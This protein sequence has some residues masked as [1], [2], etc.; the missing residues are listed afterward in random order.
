MGRHRTIDPADILAAAEQ[1]VA[2]DGA[3]HLTIDAVAAEA[4]ISKAS[5]I[6]NFASKRDLIAAVVKKAVAADNELHATA[7]KKLGD[8]KNN[9]IRGR[10]AAAAKPLPDDFRPIALQLCAALAQ[11][12]ELR[13]II[14]TNQNEVIDAIK[15]TSS[16]PRGA[17]LAYLALEG[18]KLLESLDYHQWSA[19]ERARIVREIE[20]LVDKT[21]EAK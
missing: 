20:W 19:K 2:R 8:A 6:Y 21:P 13:S 7:T 12:R 3:A 17:L 4:K 10:L 18:L 15:E 1:V 9:V 14:Q 5:V 16:K 11:D